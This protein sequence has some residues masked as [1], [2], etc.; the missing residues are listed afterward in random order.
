MFLMY[1]LQFNA[2]ALRNGILTLY[3]IIIKLSLDL[4]LLFLLEE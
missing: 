2:Y 3:G 4:I 1:V